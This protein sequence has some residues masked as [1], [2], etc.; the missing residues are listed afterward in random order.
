MAGWAVSSV[1][2]LN[3]DGLEDVIVGAPAPY[4]PAKSYVSVI[5][6][7]RRRGGQTT[8]PFKHSFKIFGRRWG[9]KFGYS[10]DGLADFS[11][12]GHLDFAVGAPG[13]S[14]GGKSSAGAT[15]VF[16]G[17]ADWDSFEVEGNTWGGY[18]IVGARE[19]GAAGLS[20][21]STSDVNGD[22]RSDLLIGEPGGGRRDSGSIYIVF[23]RSTPRRIS[24]GRLRKHGLRLSRNGLRRGSQLGYA[25]AAY[26][27][28]R[29]TVILAGAP[30]ARSRRHPGAGLVVFT[31]LSPSRFDQPDGE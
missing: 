29:K 25:V 13:R 10:V 6:G 15:Y 8:S 26:Q 18:R 14:V 21:S 11:G 17:R 31:F 1:G 2:D 4:V 5:Y 23:G 9:E 7:D 12:D 27:M 3:Q 28:A 19:L 20:I 16:F 22:G 30:G 24:L